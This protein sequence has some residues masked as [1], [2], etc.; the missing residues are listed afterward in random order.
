M[1]LLCLNCRGLG[2]PEAVPEVRSLCEL[3]CPAIVFLSE[4]Q[5]FDDRIDG[6][7]R[8]I[9]LA[10]G[11]GIGSHGRGGGLELLW[12]NEV[13]LRLQ[14]CDRLHIDVTVAD[15]STGVERW[16]FTGFC[17]ESRREMCHR[18]WDCLRM[19]SHQ[20]TLPWLCAGDFNEVLEVNE[21]FGGT[22]RMERQMEGFRDAVAH[23]GFQELGFIG[24]P[25]TWD[26]RQHGGHNIKVRLDRG[27]ATATFMELFHGVNVWHQQ[28]TE[29]DH[30]GLVI[31]CLGRRGRRRWRQ[32]NFRYENMWQRHP[33]YMDFVRG[34]W[35]YTRGSVDMSG[36]HGRLGHMRE[37]LQTWDIDI[38]GS[39]H[40]QLASMRKELEQV[41]S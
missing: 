4:T 7:L 20:S 29:L 19:L 8:S 24:L 26:N 35:E 40:K 3:H 37:V 9:G 16:R 34:S 12:S 33:E 23:R 5:F 27:L 36:V 6:L 1:K 31:E 30:C 11:L 39:V 25:Y 28:T 17:G 10:H 13:V 21:Q 14:N 41:R 22:G 18:S 38:F 32:K 2:W 15:P